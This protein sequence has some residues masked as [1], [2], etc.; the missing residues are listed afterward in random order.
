MKIFIPLLYCVGTNWYKTLTVFRS[1]SF[2]SV[3]FP[4]NER[5]NVSFEFKIEKSTV[6]HACQFLILKHIL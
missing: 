4:L 1:I 5:K 2:V 6:Y 3:F